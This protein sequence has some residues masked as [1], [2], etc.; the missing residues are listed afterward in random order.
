MAARGA[1]AVS[2]AVVPVLGTDNKTSR[3]FQKTSMSAP[4]PELL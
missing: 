4:C 1:S 2:Q 3:S